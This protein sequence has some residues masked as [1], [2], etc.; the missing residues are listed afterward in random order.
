MICRKN[1][2]IRSN[3]WTMPTCEYLAHSAKPEINA[4]AQTYSEHAA[5]VINEATKKAETAGYYCPSLHKPL[6]YMVRKAAAHHDIGKLSDLNQE[7][8]RRVT[9]QR[10]PIRHWDA[11]SLILL[12]KRTL[13]DNLAAWLVYAHHKGLGSLPEQKHRKQLAFRSYKEDTR[14]NSEQFLD[15]YKYRHSQCINI[16]NDNTLT[17]DF[18]NTP[19]LMRIALSCLVDAD[20]GDT[21]EH[22]RKYQNPANEIRSTPFL[23]PKKRAKKLDAYVASLRP[24]DHYRMKI[25]QTCMASNTAAGMYSCDS[26]VGSGK[27]TAVMRHLLEAAARKELRRIFVILPFTNII[28][29]SVEIYRESLLLSGEFSEDVVA[30]HHHKS[31]YQSLLARQFAETW[32]SPIV[33]TTAVQFFETLAAEKPSDLRKLHQIP[34]SAIFID[35]SHAVLPTK[36]WRLAWLWLKE[37]AESWG[38]HL[39]Y[40]SGSPV[41]Y[42][43]LEEFAGNEKKQLPELIPVALRTEGQQREKKRILFKQLKKNMAI[44]EFSDWILEHPGPR[45]VIMNTVQ[46]AAV[47]AQYLRALNSSVLHLSTALTPLDRARTLRRIKNR[48]KNKNRMDWTLVATSMVEAGVNF[49]FNIG[50]RESC[51]LMSLI[52]TSGR[53]NRNAENNESVVWD[54]TTV[55]DGLLKHHPQFKRSSNILSAMFNEFNDNLQASHCTEA[56]LR[57]IRESN[58]ATPQYDPICK[59]ES[60]FDFLEVSELFKVIDSATRTVVVNDILFDRLK[61]FDFPDRKTLMENSVQIWSKRLNELGIQEIN[62]TGIYAWTL[63]YDDFIGYMAGLL[64]ISGK[65]FPLS[66]NKKGL[67]QIPLIV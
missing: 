50:F 38:C 45:L 11:G 57:E 34:G 27:T 22:Y 41:N 13:P 1:L 53:I 32:S 7:I 2:K 52:Q 29:Q 40:A 24:K 15:T 9:S 64:E 39:V 8:L 5:A 31:D 65:S 20:H 35:E 63:G 67:F 66:I 6:L 42:W 21:A 26:P 3:W 10:L 18:T 28:D 4:S 49:S 43:E 58:Y 19:L 37:L 47:L 17:N 33:V 61:N 25:Y 48:L 14:E 30:A 12:K 36:L 51:S 46:S 55:E 23:K 56:V 60:A 59:A 62:D 54:F 16:L 44:G